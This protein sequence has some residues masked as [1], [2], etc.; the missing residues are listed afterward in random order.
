MKIS[1]LVQQPE[2]KSVPRGDGVRADRRYC[3]GKCKAICASKGGGLLDGRWYCAACRPRGNA[4]D[5]ARWARRVHEH[6]VDSGG[7]ITPDEAVALFGNPPTRSSAATT[8]YAAMRKGWF[9]RDTE[10]RYRAV[11]PGKPAP[12]RVDADLGQSYF[13]GLQRVRSVFELGGLP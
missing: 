9:T 8:L 3:T 7:P 6:L 4:K 2:S 5:V 1:S 10:M 11:K 12:R 13:T